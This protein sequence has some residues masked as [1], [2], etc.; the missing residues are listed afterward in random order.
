MT[1]EHGVCTCHSVLWLVHRV[2][3]G[4]QYSPFHPL[5]PRVGEAPAHWK[6]GLSPQTVWL[7]SLELLPSLPAGVEQPKGAV[8][9]ALGLCD[10]HTVYYYCLLPSNKLQLKRC[11][12][13]AS[14]Q[15][16]DAEAWPQWHA[17]D[18]FTTT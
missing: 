1:E 6:T 9:K 4:P 17:V 8:V 18:T 3:M 5:H 2:L 16:S 13:F 7:S 11:L 12:H 14:V 15:N 10:T